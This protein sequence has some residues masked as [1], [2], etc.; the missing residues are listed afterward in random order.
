MAEDTAVPQS[1]TPVTP[2]VTP[3]DPVVPVT[4]PVTPPADTPPVTP[5]A[6]PVTPPVTPPATPPVTPPKLS[7]EDVTKMRETIKTEVSETVSKSILQK[8][9]DALGFTKKETEELPTD[10]PSLQ[11]LIDSS[12]AD[13]FKSQTQTVEKQDE[14]DATDRQT[15]IDSTVKGWHFQFSE[16]SRLGKVPVIKDATDPTD[17]GV[18]ARRKLIMSIGTIIDETRKTNPTSD[19]VPSIS[20]VLVRFPDVLKGPPGANLPI[21][22]DTAVRAPAVALDYEKDVAGK[23]FQQIVDSGN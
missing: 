18:V 23:S 11:K 2:P 15:R 20:E 5:P 16:L 12:V 1:T 17:E 13:K 4:P 9:G 14:Q 3:V 8:I 21:S 22:G 6:D 19:H 10:K 7:E